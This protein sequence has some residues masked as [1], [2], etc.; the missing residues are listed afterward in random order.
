M[1]ARE[2]NGFC[3][4]RHLVDPVA[5]HRQ[6][7]AVLAVATSEL[8]GRDINHVQG[9]VNS[10]HALHHYPFF[11]E[12]LHGL[13]MRNLASVYLGESVRP[14]AAELFAKPAKVGLPS[15]WHQDNAYWCLSP[16]VGVTIWIALDRCDVDNGALMY[17]CG[18]HRVGALPHDPSYVPGSSLG[19]ATAHLPG[20]ERVIPWL[21]PG[22]ALLHHCLTV[23]GS[24]ANTSERARCGVTLQYAGSSTTVDQEARHHYTQSLADQVAWRKRAKRGRW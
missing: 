19:I 4:V 6:V 22:D 20:D 7:D 23:H 18:S 13:S 15:P 17:I 12:L 8:S 10:I 3:V 21:Q 14:Q 24:L 9:A 5:L 11:A 16:P 2:R 1:T